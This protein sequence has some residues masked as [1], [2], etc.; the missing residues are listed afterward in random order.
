MTNYTAT[1]MLS[2]LTLFVLSILVHENA[3]LPVAVKR[4]FYLTYILVLLATVSEWLGILLNGMPIWTMGLHR[5]V[6]CVDYITT[7]AVGV[8][9]ACQV[10]DE[11]EWE[12]HHWVIGI[13]MLNALLQI[14]SIFTG[15][16][17]YVDGTNHY[18]H[19]PLYIVYTIFYCIAIA[20]L[21]RSFLAYSRDFK[22]QNKG[23]IFS[24]IVLC[25]M[26][27]VLQEF[28]DGS[29]RT[30]C[31]VLVMGSLLLFIHYSE[32]QQQKNDER[33]LQ[34]KALIE[35]DALTGVFSR[36]SYTMALNEYHQMEA[37]P[38]G[39]VV[40]SIDING[41]KFANDTQ[42]H[43]AGDR[44][45]CNAADCLKEVFGKD[46]NC[47]R[48]GGDEFIAIVQ[49]RAEQIADKCKAL[50][51]ATGNREGWSFSFGYALA[52]EHP[53]LSMEELV[54]AADKMMYANKEAYH[55]RRK[56]EGYSQ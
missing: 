56:L 44:I 52:E 23:S 40:F 38:Q 55:Q 29:V 16:T 51:G 42:G 25:C 53:G 19:G 31:L 18:G 54:N 32:F 27:I 10:S 49:I 15:W 6:K 8:C 9:F 13:L 41:L 34:Q 28:S 2:C 3:R 48:V 37:L 4:R 21:L 35:T 11:N 22:K 5:I 30:S 1:V 26:G 12:K 36:Y 14:V 7:P 39:L 24:I 46:G 20:D 17:F 33:L 47:F 50:S 45:I 43:A